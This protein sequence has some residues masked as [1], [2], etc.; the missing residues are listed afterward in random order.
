[1]SDLCEWVCACMWFA[2][3][4]NK[5]QLVAFWIVITVGILY[6]NKRYQ[7]FSLFSIS[8]MICLVQISPQFVKQKDDDDSNSNR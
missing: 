8:T 4:K 5:K 7:I 3:R 1:M 2:K 6:H